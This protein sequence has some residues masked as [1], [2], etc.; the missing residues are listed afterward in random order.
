MIVVVEGPSAA[1]K[2]DVVRALE[3]GRGGAGARA[4]P[5]RTTRPWSGNGQVTAPVGAATSTC[6]VA[7]DRCCRRYGALAELDPARVQWTFPEE[8]STALAADRHDV[9]LF[10]QWMQSLPRTVEV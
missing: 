1:G 5:C 6:T 3:R 8:M 2:F 9:S 10:D 4:H 7:S